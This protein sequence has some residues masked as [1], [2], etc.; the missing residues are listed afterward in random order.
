M[1]TLPLLGLR[2]PVSSITHL[3][4]AVF[5]V[6]VTLLFLRLAPGDA[7]KRRALLVYGLSMV[8]LYA[9]S[10]VYHAIP[11][12]RNDPLVCYF[13]RIDVSAIFVLIAGSFT[14]IITVVLTGRSRRDMLV[15]IW[16]LAVIGIA[17]KWLAPNIPHPIT[18]CTF[19]AAGLPGFL[20][21]RAYRSG[22][23]G[24]GLVWAM[25]GCVCFALGGI[26]DVADWPTPVPGYVNAHELTHFLDMTGSAAHV[27][28]MMM[29]IVP[30]ERAAE[31]VE[32]YRQSE[33]VL[34]NA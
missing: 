32:H 3:A 13:R 9:A 10:G 14:P 5:A 33:P 21:V 23:G 34:V 20:P 8:V 30:F 7:A 1:E 18:V 19:A 31:Y 15:L 6:Y 25:F 24:R 26:F 16:G 29:F 12:E 2:E 22:V 27:L 11:G 4:T 28:F 17:L